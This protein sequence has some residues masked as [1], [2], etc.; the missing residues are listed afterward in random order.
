VSHNIVEIG[1]GSSIKSVSQI[2]NEVGSGGSEV[3]FKLIESLRSVF[4]FFSEGLSEVFSDFE[5]ILGDGSGDIIIFISVISGSVSDNFAGNMSDILSADKGVS[6]I[7]QG[8]RE[9]SFFFDEILIS[10]QQ[11]IHEEITS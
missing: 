4:D 1:G 10:F 2:F 9:K 8:V 7:T 5:H 6:C 3:L 11:V